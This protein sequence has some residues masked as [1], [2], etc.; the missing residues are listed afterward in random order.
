M[1]KP[2]YSVADHSRSRALNASTVRH[3]FLA[4][5][6]LAFSLQSY[7]AQTHNH[8][9]SPGAPQTNLQP[10]AP[11]PAPDAPKHDDGDSCAL[12]RVVA[13]LGAFFTPLLLYISLPAAAPAFVL[14]LPAPAQSAFLL[15]R[16]SQQRGPPHP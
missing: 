15:E 9:V 14:P 3:F 13:Q 6:L 12:C 10:S 7:I 5:L 1:K 2:A 8:G 16:G 11:G 4:L